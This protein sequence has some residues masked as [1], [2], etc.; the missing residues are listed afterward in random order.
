MAI[1]KAPGRIGVGLAHMA[2]LG[3]LALG[4]VRMTDAPAQ[5]GALRPLS[6]ASSAQ[7]PPVEGP[8]RT[9]QVVLLVIDGARWQDIFAGVDPALAQRNGMPEDAVVAAEELTPNLH[10]LARRGVGVGGEGAPFLASGPNFVS[11]PGYAEI[12]TGRP[13]KCFENDCPADGAPTLVDDFRAAPGM[14]DGRVV[15]LSSWDR[16]ANLGGAAP[17]RAIISTGR[18]AGHNLEALRADDKTAFLLDRGREAQPSP[19]HG[20]YRPDGATADLAVQVLST[21][22]PRFLFLSLGDADERAHAGDYAGY[23]AAVR[24]ADATLGR[25]VAEVAAWGEAGRHVTFAVTADHGRCDGFKDHGRDCAESAR[26]F[27]VMGGGAVPRR[28][29]IAL[30]EERHLRDIAPTLRALANIPRSMVPDAGEKEAGTA[31]VEMAS[32]RE[33]RVASAPVTMPP[34]GP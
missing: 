3:A 12:L 8:P 20:D 21:A 22:R 9:D 15:M 18:V 13:A 24:A 6:A 2:V 31:I 7:A 26:T 11:L 16:L 27:L 10:A 29:F 5:R 28:G 14:R 23:L 4:C 33:L 32:P 30:K 1:Q 19:G 34:A 17:D 25:M